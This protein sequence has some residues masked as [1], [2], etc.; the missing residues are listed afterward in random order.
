M[1]VM[2]N[3]ICPVSKEA[4]MKDEVIQVEYQGKKINLCC[5]MCLK[6]FN[7]DPEKYI[8]MMEESMKNEAGAAAAG[9]TQE[10]PKGSV[11][12]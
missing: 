6:D 8:K 1:M 5:K 2:D 9:A 7:K 4:V 11:T 12:N 10:E 3:K